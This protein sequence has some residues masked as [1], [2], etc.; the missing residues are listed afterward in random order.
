MWKIRVSLVTVLLMICKWGVDLFQILL[1]HIFKPVL[2]EE[3]CSVRLLKTNQGVMLIESD[4]DVNDLTK[5]DDDDRVVKE[6]TDDIWKN[7]RHLKPKKRRTSKHESIDVEDDVFQVIP[8]IIRRARP[9]QHRRPKVKHHIKKSRRRF[10]KIFMLPILKQLVRDKNLQ[11]HKRITRR[12]TT[13]R[14]PIKTF[15]T[16]PTDRTFRTI[17]TIDPTLPPLFTRPTVQCP[18]GAPA[19]NST[20]APNLSSSDQ[21]S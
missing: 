15:P 10:K 2:V 6:N 12:T 19:P 4:E 7:L 21:H 1:T 18:S 3:T 16:R 20:S 5:L 11:K 17:P 13:D 8:L 9:L 14:P